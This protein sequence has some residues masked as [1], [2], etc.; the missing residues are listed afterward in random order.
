M[1]KNNKVRIIIILV[2]VFS[3]ILT[4]GI[5]FAKYA[6]SNVLNYYYKSKEF[7][8]YSNDLD[9]KE[10]IN[11]NNNWDGDKVY[12]NIK[13][14]LNDSLVTEYDIPYKVD[15]STNN[16]N[17]K[18]SINDLSSTYE[19]VLSSSKACFNTKDDLITDI[20]NMQ[21]CTSNGY[22]WLNNKSDSNL[23]FNVVSLD[24]SLIDNVIVDIIVTSKEPYKK[25]L[26]GK[27][28]LSKA[29]NINNDVSLNYN[30]YDNY[31][32]VIVSNLLS[33]KKNYTLEFDSSNLRVDMNDKLEIK[34]KD[35]NDFINSVGFQ[36]D[37]NSN[38]KIIFYK[39][40]LSKEFNENSLNILVND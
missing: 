40:D 13:N 7:Y 3:L 9:T 27:F 36:L 35:S 1:K 31:V 18:C 24:N 15:C 26:K 16:S 33:N 38:I 30:N 11:T 39:T 32:E 4:Y 14:Y 21:D 5:S 28:L 6:Y 19:G 34:G 12:F 17:Y 22:E 2:L 37:A 25:I 8:F 29:S 23:Y 10:I 20:N